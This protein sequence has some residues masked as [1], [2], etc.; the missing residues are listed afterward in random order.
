MQVVQWHFGENDVVSKNC[1]PG[2]IRIRKD[3]NQSKALPNFSIKWSDIM[4]IGKATCINLLKHVFLYY[5][6]PF[7]CQNMGKI[8]NGLKFGCELI[9]ILKLH[10]FVRKDFHHRW[11]CMNC[12]YWCLIPLW[13]SLSVNMFAIIHVYIIKLIITRSGV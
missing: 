12:Q 1:K 11:N 7:F 13:F 9:I 2:E 5:C 10:V 4:V 8:K 3:F 6:K